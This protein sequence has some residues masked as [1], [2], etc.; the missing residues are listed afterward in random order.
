MNLR[1]WRWN[2][3]PVINKNKKKMLESTCA[4]FVYRTISS[5]QELNV[6]ESSITIR[7]PVGLHARPAA[8]FVQT[9]QKF[10]SKISVTYSAKTANAKSLLALLG[11]G[12]SKDANISIKADGA[13][14]EA[15]VSAL[16][17]LVE[18]NFGERP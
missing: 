1:H 18:S 7:H 10:V 12:V 5:S 3:P 9:A 11:L 16:V 4:S 15:A 2:C 13:D 6:K 14:E 17:A 8:L